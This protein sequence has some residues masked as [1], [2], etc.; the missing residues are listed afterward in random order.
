[1]SQKNFFSRKREGV[2]IFYS[3]TETPIYMSQFQS[4]LLRK[5]ALPK[6]EKFSVEEAISFLKEKGYRIFKEEG[7]DEHRLRKENPEIY[8]QY[9]LTKEI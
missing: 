9:L 7:I 3:F 1:M 6:K 8:N 5:Q 4:L 2:K